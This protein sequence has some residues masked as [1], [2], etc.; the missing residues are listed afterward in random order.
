MT[1][2]HLQICSHCLAFPVQSELATNSKD[3]GTHDKPQHQKMANGASVVTITMQ[4][5][6]GTYQSCKT[7]PERRKM[8]HTRQRPSAIEPPTLYSS[9][10]PSCCWGAPLSS[11]L[12][13]PRFFGY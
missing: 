7:T 10:T 3:S 8:A 13:T 2:S 11:I 5:C 12:A 1:Q 9:S 6:A 4:T